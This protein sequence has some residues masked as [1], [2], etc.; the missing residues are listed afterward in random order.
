LPIAQAYGIIE[1]GIVCINTTKPSDKLGSVGRVLPDYSISIRNA[2]NYQHKSRMCGDIFF[3]GPG[4]FDA[5][6]NPWSDANLIMENGWFDT[7][8]IGWMDNDGYVF[9]VARKKNII[10][11]AGMKVFPQEV[12]KMLDMQ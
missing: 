6:F 1:L 4:F 11:T 8:D 5:Y 9:I 10:N 3:K 7:G 2:E 12:E